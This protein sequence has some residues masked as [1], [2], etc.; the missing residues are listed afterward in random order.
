MFV[1]ITQA[2]FKDLEAKAKASDKFTKFQM[3]EFGN[4]TADT[5]DVSFSFHYDSSAEKLYLQVGHKHSLAAKLAGDNVIYQHLAE[6][7]H[8]LEPLADNVPVV[9]EH[10]VITDSNPQP[11]GD[12]EPSPLA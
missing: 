10:E 11:T 2:D 9:P 5:S 1:Y 8:N 6:T 4:G 7:I 3:D 12:Q